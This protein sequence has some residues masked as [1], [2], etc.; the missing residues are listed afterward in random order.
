MPGSPLDGCFAKLD[1]ANTHI[2]DLRERIDE[3]VATANPHT[4]VAQQNVEQFMRGGPIL[5]IIGRI[6]HDP[7]PWVSSI[8][9]DVV[10][11]LRSALDHVVWG[12]SVK[13]GTSP[14]VIP[15]GPWRKVAFPIFDDAAKYATFS[16]PMIA[17]IRPGSI[18]AS[19]VPKIEAVQPF[20]TGQPEPEREPLMV[21][22]E[23]WNLD[24]HRSLVTTAAI[25]ELED[26]IFEPPFEGVPRIEYGISFKRD[27]GPFKDGDV[28]GGLHMLPKQARS[29]I[30]EWDVDP[31]G[32]FGIAFPEGFPAYGGILV[33]TLIA[34]YDVTARTIELF[35][36]ELA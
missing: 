3:W 18:R 16:G 35:E 10:H 2:E 11:N 31:K 28:L 22:H 12:L 21:L 20:A 25:G 32:A 24:K 14:P 13:S 1:R 33:P 30:P 27:A 5:D 29:T 34:L 26:V 7:P 15:A 6:H 19:S 8:I 17:M 23:L 36:P 4:L 9:G